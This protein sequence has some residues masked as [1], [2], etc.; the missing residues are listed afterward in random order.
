[1]SRSTSL[2][3][4][5]GVLLACESSGPAGGPPLLLLHALG[6]DR[7]TWRHVADVF[8]GDGWRTLA[9]D[10]RGHG[11]SGHPGA[12]AFESMRDDV[13]A[14]LD[15][16]RIDEVTLVAHSMG[17]VVACLIAMDRP[18]TVRRLVLEEG[19][20]PFPADPPRPVPPAPDGP[21]PYDWRVVPA[22]AV[23]RNAPPARHWDGLAG[24]TAPT[25]IVA[26]G[27]RS[28]LRQD[29]LAQVAGRIPDARLIT[30]DGGHMVHDERPA[31]F[32]AV[33]RDFLG[34]PPAPDAVP[35]APFTPL[36]VTAARLRE[37]VAEFAAVLTDSVESGACVG[38]HGPL[39]FE[40]AAGWWEALAPAV[41]AGRVRLWAVRDAD[42]AVCGTVQLIPAESRNDGHRAEMAKLMVRRDARG[43]GLAR[44]LVRTAE[45][46]A[47]A[48]GV[49][50]LL[51]DTQTGGAAD[52]LCRAEGFTPAG[53]VP[54]YAADPEGVPRPTTFFYKRLG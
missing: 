17:T 27:P 21:T 12:Y 7:T 36:P 25:L 14:L 47:K 31:E 49:R 13:L 20:L 51:L 28:H 43:R 46:A 32:L 16:L 34:A 50:L 29:Q 1:M 22:I 8:A 15:E 26:G 53:T 4:V 30:I 24:I 37:S 2:Y 42:R 5:N 9:V 48:E 18:R 11:D 23:Q 45:A 6:E 40:D 3:Q 39:A 33:L 10:L 52:S 44:L 41:A 38:F 54:G 35:A 19:P